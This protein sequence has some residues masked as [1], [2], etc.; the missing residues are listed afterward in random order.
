MATKI[1]Q[2]EQNAELYLK[3]AK[4]R[5]DR[6][7]FEG[8]LSSLLS[9]YRISKDYEILAEMA[10]IYAEIGELEASNQYWFYYLAKAPKIKWAEAY[11]ELAKNCFDLNDIVL[12]AFYTNECAKLGQQIK[13]IDFALELKDA[14]EQIVG[15]GRD[16]FLIDSVRIKKEVVLLDKVPRQLEE[17]RFAEIFLI[18]SKADLEALDVEECEAYFYVCQVN[19]EYERAKMV[20]DSL[21]RRFKNH[22]KTLSV[23]CLYYKYIGDEESA[24]IHLERLLNYPEKNEEYY[25]ELLTV[26]RFLRNFKCF[27]Y[28]WVS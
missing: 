28:E 14:V 2:F 10:S 12:S 27:C 6:G 8:C 1:L 23:N 22:L 15:M 9:A 4:N 20:V 25:L 19:D 16:F 24:K 18:Y 5:G 13:D 26:S 3:V 11:E 17:Q 7:D 21:N